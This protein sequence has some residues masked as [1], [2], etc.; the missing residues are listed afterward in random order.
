LIREYQNTD[1][2]DLLD[3]SQ[4]IWEGEDYL[5]RRIDNYVKNPNSY[6]MVA[7]EKDKVISIGNFEFLNEE[8]IWIEALRTHPNFRNKGWAH[9]CSQ[10]QII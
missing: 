3:I 9:G 2:L 1:F 6:P 7:L 4:H 5:P 8:I 10:I